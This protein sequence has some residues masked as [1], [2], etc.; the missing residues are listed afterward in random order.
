MWLLIAII[1]LAIIV[2]LIVAYLIYRCCKQPADA[3]ADSENDIE[4]MGADYMP[5]ESFANASTASTDSQNQ[6]LAGIAMSDHRRPASAINIHFTPSDDSVD[7]RR[8]T[9]EAIDRRGV[10]RS[11]ELAEV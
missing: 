5:R 11:I 6:I 4:S 8:Q 2:A 1:A 9:P 10:I 3:G 7:A